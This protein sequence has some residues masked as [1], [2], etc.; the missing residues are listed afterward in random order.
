VG[1]RPSP[2][3]GNTLLGANL[4]WEKKYQHGEWNGLRRW[5]TFVDKFC[6]EV[7]AL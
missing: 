2:Y 5:N 1:A 6:L 3:I 4:S 7:V